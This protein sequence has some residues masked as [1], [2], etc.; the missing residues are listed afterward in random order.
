MASDQLQQQWSLER[1]AVQFTKDFSLFVL[2]TCILLHGGAII[3]LISLLSALVTH[4]TTETIISI[5]SIRYA[6]A[7]FTSGLIV[8]V[9]A[10]VCGYFNFL[11]NQGR[12]QP[13]SEKTRHAATALTMFS[14]VLFVIGVGIVIFPWN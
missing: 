13:K 6:I 5:N 7:F 2:R 3:A 12:D 9:L 11:A 8:T 14:L 1:D 10:G 4:Q